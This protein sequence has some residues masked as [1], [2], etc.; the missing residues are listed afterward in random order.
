MVEVVVAAVAVIVGGG[1][2]TDDGTGAGSPGT[3]ATLSRSSAA[4]IIEIGNLAVLAAAS[5]AGS[6][7]ECITLR[8]VV[9][10]FVCAGS[11]G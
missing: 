1:A 10:V 7:A 11:R 6:F 8:T 2:G 4:G 9:C 3:G 5:T